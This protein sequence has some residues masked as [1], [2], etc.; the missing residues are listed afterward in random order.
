MPNV[1]AAQTN[2]RGAVC[3]NSLVCPKLANRSQ[4]LM[5]RSLPYCG[6]M[7]RSLFNKFFSNCR[8]VP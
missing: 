3:W 1:M 4:P 2:V 8:Y 5:G 7:L 6:D